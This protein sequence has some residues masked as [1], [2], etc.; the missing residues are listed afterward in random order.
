MIGGGSGGWLQQ[1]QNTA[2]EIERGKEWG[3]FEG[4]DNLEPI[5]QSAQWDPTTPS[6]AP[7]AVLMMSYYSKYHTDLARRPKKI[8]PMNT[9][10]LKK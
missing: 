1:N 3:H 8:S 7:L 4:H 10:Q 6:H 5:T 9:F 2:G